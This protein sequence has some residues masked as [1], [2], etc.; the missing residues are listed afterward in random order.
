[1]NSKIN[2]N[3]TKIKNNLNINNTSSKPIK[4][5]LLWTRETNS[6][7]TSPHI[8]QDTNTNIL[9]KNLIKI[10]DSSQIVKTDKIKENSTSPTI[11]K[12]DVLNYIN[13]RNYLNNSRINKNQVLNQQ[14][15]SF[16]SNSNEENKSGSKYD[17]SNSKKSDKKPHFYNNLKFKKYLN[18]NYSLN[19]NVNINSSEY[20]KN[21]TYK[22][23]QSSNGINL[24]KKNKNKANFITDNSHIFL[25][26]SKKSITKK[27]ISKDKLPKK[28]TISKKALNIS[29][30]PSNNNNPSSRFSKK[31]LSGSLNQLTSD[32][33]NEKNNNWNQVQKISFSDRIFEGDN[34]KIKN[35]EK[36]NEKLKKENDE[37][38]KKNKELIILVNKLENEILE[39]KSVIKD[40][41]NMFLQPEK[42]MINKSYNELSGQIE[43]EKENISKILNQLQQ[44]ENSNIEIESKSREDNLNININNK[45]LLNE[46]RNNFRIF[47]KNYFE[48]FN[49]VNTSNTMLNG[50]PTGNDHLKNILNSFCCF[51]DNIMN[52]LEK[53]F[54]HIEKDKNEKNIDNSNYNFIEICLINIYY[55]FVISQLFLV[56]FFERQ[57]CYYCFSI[58]DYILTSPFMIIKNNNFIKNYTRKITNLIEVYRRINEEYISKF[59]EQ[60]FFYLDNYIKLFNIIINN[61]SDLINNIKLDT[62]VFKQNTEVLFDKDNNK[63]KIY[64]DMINNLLEKVNKGN[65]DFN[66][67]KLF[68][69]KI[70][71]KNKIN[72]IK[73]NGENF[74]KI[75]SLSNTSSKIIDNYSERP[76]FYGFLKNDDRPPEMSFEDEDI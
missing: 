66:T 44:K 50:Y 49:Q 63:Q 6:K 39:I 13:H 51:M 62:D 2:N 38:N 59:S 30:S 27:K 9:K 74:D 32:N 8:K 47:Q 40:N 15:S 37:L 55:Q 19:N 14:I 65:I 21:N 60:T 61:K 52:K 29:P 53:K 57:H 4:K 43:K 46:G 76:S 67:E 41:L 11:K 1:M 33:I 10:N 22:Y 16:Q 28:G 31:L 7:S 70:K 3:K 75:S 56:S 45:N 71:G 48:F 25:N 36:E 68:K 69:E 24:R 23:F 17:D 73:L 35:L 20:H 5:M 12:K 26:P 18:M 54:I 72:L 58:L 34:E 42:D 64:L